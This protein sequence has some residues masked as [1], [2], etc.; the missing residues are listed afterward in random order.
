MKPDPEQLIEEKWRRFGL[1]I[2]DKRTRRGWTQE[3]CADRAGMRRQ[4]WGRLEK[5]AP[6]KE[7]TVIR[8]ADAL[9]ADRNEA[10]RIIKSPEPTNQEADRAEEAAQAAELIE[11]WMTLS[12]ESRAQAL[13]FL[14]F[15]RE[16]HPE[17]L[18][19]LHPKVKLVT[20]K[21]FADEYDPDNPDVIIE[22]PKSK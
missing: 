10:L 6:T 14:R 5:G 15:L 3:F 17:G 11:N 20:A 1:W 8:V 2:T 7:I 13:E 9:E 21:E 19:T 12:P 18:K 4:Q 22:K 16:K